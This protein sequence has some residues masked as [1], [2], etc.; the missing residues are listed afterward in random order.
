VQHSLSLYE[1]ELVSDPEVLLVKSRII[2]KVCGLFG[3]LSEQYKSCSKSFNL[4]IDIHKNA[5]ISR[6]ENYERLPYVMLDY[7]RLF[8]KADI[9]AIRTFFWWGNF[10]SITLQL[11]GYYT[12]LFASKLQDAINK[13]LLNEW[14]ITLSDDQWQ[15]HFKHGYYSLIEKEK[16][17]EFTTLPFIKIATKIPLN[18]WDRANDFL[19]K[20]FLQ[21]MQVLCAA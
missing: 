16:N 15:H 8:G 4:P 3:E 17:Y 19:Y 6:G 21:I 9:F 13:G 12:T 7:P 11:E 14:Y 5:K 18:E 20:K 10:F 2:E 1:L